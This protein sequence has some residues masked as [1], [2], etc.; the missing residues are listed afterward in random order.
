MNPRVIKIARNV[1]FLLSI[2]LMITAFVFAQK[3]TDKNVCRS[4]NIYIEN[5]DLSFITKKDIIN[6]I[7]AQ[8]IQSNASY[9]NAIDIQTLENTLKDN[10]WIKNATVFLGADNSLNV[11]VDQK[12]P[13][14]R[15]VENDNTDYAYYLDEFAN[16]IPLSPQYSPRLPVVT[17]HAIGFNHDDLQLK[18]DLV[19]VS[20]YIQEDSF[21][22]AAITQINITEKNSIELIPAF[23]S[24]IIVFGNI[25]DM[26]NKFERLLLFYKQGMNTIDWNLY[27]EID[28]RFKGQVVCRN[29]RGEILSKDPYAKI[30]NKPVE[31]LIVKVA[32]S[33]A[34]KTT[35]SV[36]K[37]TTATLV[38]E[39]PKAIT[40]TNVKPIS[41]TTIAK[42]KDNKPTPNKENKPTPKI[43]TPQ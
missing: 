19:A 25:E 43:I 29:M 9:T 3:S 27:D 34:P 28:L 12:R 41:K 26:E 37:K 1:V 24:Q 40:K 8:G 4:L 30:I 22:N 18:S 31:K 13:I 11:R 7:E 14:V 10:K 42:P 36:E 5:T 16:P 2:P 32:N 15:I 39:K 23:G 17:S 21:W 33:S 20:E 35:V 6:T 38:K